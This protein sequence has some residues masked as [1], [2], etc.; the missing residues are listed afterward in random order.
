MRESVNVR[1]VNR[2][3]DYVSVI[4]VFHYDYDDI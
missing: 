2:V 4:P 3:S 1:S